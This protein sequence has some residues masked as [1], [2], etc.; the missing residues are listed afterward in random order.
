MGNAIVV[1]TQSLGTSVVLALSN[2]IFQEGLRVQLPIYAPAV[3]PAAIIAAG[4]THFRD[5]VSAKDLPGVLKAY[6]LAINHV[7]YPIIPLC[8]I[9]I[10]TSLYLGGRV[11]PSYTRRMRSEV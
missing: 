10:V 8:G 3:N 4:A 9:A 2:M 11:L 1:F 5:I 7:F 6:S